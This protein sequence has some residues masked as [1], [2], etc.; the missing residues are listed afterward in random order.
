VASGPSF[1]PDS[2]GF[3][4]TSCLEL[5]LAVIVGNLATLRPLYRHT[6]NSFRSYL[7]GSRS[8]KNES[9]TKATPDEQEKGLA[10]H[11]E[12][13]SKSNSSAEDWNN[14][15]VLLSATQEE[16][17]EKKRASDRF[18]SLTLPTLPIKSYDDDS[19]LMRSMDSK[20][21]ETGNATHGSFSPLIS[22]Q[23]GDQVPFSSTVNPQ[24]RPVVQP[25]R[26]PL[27]RHDTEAS[28][29]SSWWNFRGKS[30]S[31]TGRSQTN[32]R[33]KP[34][35]GESASSGPIQLANGYRKWVIRR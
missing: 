13:R 6:K 3:I 18:N 17:E 29:R 34:N 1:W 32:I 22:K 25:Q 30:E 11:G 28:S 4:I 23:S 5:T 21:K 2:Q 10:H 24:Y 14:K 8:S 27:P 15:D 33:R 26:Q 9:Y 31:E 20:F 12:K 35:R 7:S 16:G 19:S